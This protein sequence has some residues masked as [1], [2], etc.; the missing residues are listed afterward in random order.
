MRTCLKAAESELGQIMKYVNQNS[1]E[2]HDTDL[3][4]TLIWHLV[5]AQ[6]SLEM[7]H[8]LDEYH[9]YPENMSWEHP[10]I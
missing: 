2:P 4:N 6:Y 10:I 9:E 7:G 3:F 5:A 8:G 1:L